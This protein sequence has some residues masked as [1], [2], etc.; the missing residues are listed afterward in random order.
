MTENTDEKV[1]ERAQEIKAERGISLMDAMI[2]AEEEL[3]PKPVTPS[4]FTVTIP[5][6]PRVARWVLA[7]FA[8]TSTHST[9][10]RLGA[11]LSSMLNRSRVSA[12]RANQESPDIGEGGA[13]S[14][15]RQEFQRKAPS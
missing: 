2:R 11:Y 4:E 12:M 14:M 1:L 7:E 3:A 8:A 5:V 9:E 6:K 13:V 10:E 15:S